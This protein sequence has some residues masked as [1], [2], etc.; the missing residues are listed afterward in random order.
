[1]KSSPAVNDSNGEN[2][3][4]TRYLI[5][6]DLGTTNCALSYIDTREPTWKTE[7]FRIAQWVDW[8]VFE[9]RE[10]L[11]SF[12][13]EFTSDESKA[14][15]VL[16][17]QANSPSHCVGFFARDAGQRHPGRRI[18]SAKSWLS[19]D[20]VDRTA[21][22]LPWHGDAD[23]ARLSPVA[24]SARYLEHLR[25]AWDH[26]H[27]NDLLA[28][29]DVVVT[30][31]ASFD[32][33]ARELTVEAAKKAGLSRVFLI[34]EPQAAFYAWI[35]RQ[36]EAWQNRVR[37]GQMILVCDIG[38]GTTDLTL[39]RVQPAGANGEEV[40][41]HRVAVGDHLILGG[42]N[43]DL[44]VAKLAE[45]KLNSTSLSADQSLSTQLSADQ[46]DRLVQVSRYVKEVMLQTDRP[47]EFTVSLPSGGSQLIGSSLQ[48]TI[49]ADEI[50]RILLEGFFPEV[51]LTDQVQTGE[52]GF[53]DFGLP[54]AADPAITRHL[55]EFLSKHRRTG[56][57]EGAVEFDERPEFILFN[58][59]VMSAPAI[60]DRIVKLVKRWFAEGSDDAWAPQVLESSRLDL[61]VSH[62]AAYY[63]GVRRGNGIRITAN[64][65]RSYYMQVTD[66]PPQGMCLIPGTAEAGQRFRTDSHPLELQIGA[67]VQFP[68]WSSSTR[69]ADSVGDLVLMDRSEASPLPPICTALVEG[70]RRESA[71]ASVVIESELS[72]IGTVGL[73]C[74][75]RASSKRW[76]LDF[77]IRSTLETDRE[78]HAGIGESAGIIDS[79]TVS[80]CCM[81]IENLFG[82]SA[83]S[84][85]LKP[86]QI[87]KRLQSI[88]E[89]GRIQWPPTFL[90]SLWQCLMDHEPGRRKSAEHESRWLNLVGFCLRPGYGVAVDDWRVSE[91]WR[92][93]HNKLAF[94]AA[95]SRTES[96][97][98]WRRISGGLTTAQQAQL[99]LPLIKTLKGN[100]RVEPH[101]GSEIWRLLGSLER[102][103]ANEK[104]T[105]GI[106]AIE[107]IQ[108]KK[109]EKMH[110]ALLWAIGRLGSRHPAYG[111][112]NG[113]VDPNEASRWT[114]SLIQTELS[115]AND[116]IRNLAIVQMARLTGDR[117][118]DLPERV[119]E[120]AA[121]FLDSKGASDD[122]VTLLRKVGKLNKEEEAAIFGDTL[123]LGIRLLRS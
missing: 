23:V 16:P 82:E 115:H 54:Y 103:S 64:L 94:P 84:S 123:P 76:R 89:L 38:G 97:I 50:D 24:A 13:Y 9:F 52:S 25:L 62:G 96:M 71:A 92:N 35:E 11:P 81:V 3:S 15:H 74:V 41:F 101:E 63:A 117:Y 119:R 53:Q 87:V 59:G 31:P 27:P 30:L 72:E 75:D 66:H 120:R 33:V 99:A 67:P 1:M 90:R 26:E 58:G 112:L 78:A 114:E 8:G 105:L 85:E 80:E 106:L 40:Q 10:T 21:E 60:Q 56:I 107:A 49:S 19:H 37:P 104:S 48:V 100:T 28:D 22:I 55:A 32:E 45:S 57:L 68:L 121:D 98:L 86:S 42:D 108:A 14:A 44:A 47:E 2:S 69:L 29:Q 4:A 5:G 113:L 102:L 70:K 65:G 88:S 93:V 109:N 111:P 118:R 91:V 110:H 77:D 39:I 116:S 36:G 79:D 61:A 12:H 18:A 46:W 95:A 20:G 6:I 83:E 43:L 122:T 7:T 73:Y 34:E 17:W 51:E